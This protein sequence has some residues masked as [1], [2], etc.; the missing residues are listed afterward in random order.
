MNS[1]LT[2]I[3]AVALDF[4]SRLGTT[5]ELNPGH[6]LFFQY[7][8]LPLSEDN[9]GEWMVYNIQDQMEIFSKLALCYKRR[10]DQA[11]IGSSVCCGPALTW[12]PA[13]P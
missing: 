6:T 13:E 10:F 11:S 2:D 5:L 12:I 9:Q 4:I 8:S 3:P 1:R 7:K